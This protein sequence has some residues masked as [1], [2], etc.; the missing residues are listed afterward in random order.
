MRILLAEDDDLSRKILEQAFTGWGYEVVAARDGLEAWDAFK[1]LEGELGMAVLDWIMP[2]LDGL[3]ICRRIRASKQAGYVYV[4]IVTSKGK[5]QDI[6]D[7]LKAG[8]DDYVSKPFDLDELGARVAV[9]ERVV[10]LE[11][12]LAKHIRTLEQALAQVKQLQG[13]LPI[14][15]YCKKVRNDQ[16]YWQEVERYIEDHT[17]AEFSHG[18]CPECMAKYVEPE[19]RKRTR[20]T[21]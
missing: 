10:N 12:D 2:G 11:R 7:G 16:N 18:I 21:D 6:V 3:E 14:C 1:K 20:K 13:L 19:L 5:A 17:E 15:C 8:A 4:I 9:G